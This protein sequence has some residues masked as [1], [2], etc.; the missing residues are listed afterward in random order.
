MIDALLVGMECKTNC[1]Y[2]D[3]RDYFNS[4]SGTIVYSGAIDE[5]FGHRLGH[6]A[7]RS[8]R[9]EQEPSLIATTKGT[10]LLITQIVILLIQESLS[11]SILIS[12]TRV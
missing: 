8:L 11:I 7:Y 10:R 4:I 6:L 5:Y 12:T 1:D 9:F 2:F 3:D